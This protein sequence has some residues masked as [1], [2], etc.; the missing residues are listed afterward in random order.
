MISWPVHRSNFARLSGKTTITCRPRYRTLDETNL[1][2]MDFYI[3]AKCTKRN[4]QSGFPLHIR[5]DEAEDR[6]I[7]IFDE[8]GPRSITLNSYSGSLQPKEWNYRRH[9]LTRSLYPI[10]EQRLV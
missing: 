4:P 2:T 5:Y 8:M 9:W 10:L 7:H 3:I 6:N 1:V